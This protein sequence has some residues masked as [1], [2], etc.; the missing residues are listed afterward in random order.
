MKKILTLIALV[1]LLISTPLYAR[2]VTFMDTWKDWPNYGTDIEDELGT[3]NI[4]YM[5]VVISDSG[6]LDAVQIAID[7]SRNRWQEFNSL[8]INSWAV[9]SGNSGQEDWDFYVLDGTRHRDG[10]FSVASGYQYT[11]ASGSGV[12][13]GNPN[14]IKPDYLTPVAG[15][16]AGDWVSSLEK[17]DGVY[18]WTYTFGS[19]LSIDLNRGFSIA[20]APWCA[21]DVIGGEMSPVPEPATMVL[22]GLGLLGMAGIARRGLPR[23]S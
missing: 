23:A 4:E 6:Y 3:P 19:A 22:V 10:I 16:T 18:L 2:T 8:F 20:F 17:I 1:L 11:T 21:N 13:T 5:K 12:R 15:V 14:G 7:D 9:D